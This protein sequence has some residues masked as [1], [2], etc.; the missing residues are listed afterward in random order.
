MGQA[1][2][3]VVFLFIIWKLAGF[4]INSSRHRKINCKWI[5]NK[6]NSHLNQNFEPI[7]LKVFKRVLKTHLNRLKFERL[8]ISAMDEDNILAMEFEIPD[9]GL[10]K[11]EINKLTVLTFGGNLLYDECAI[12]LNEFQAEQQL[13]Q[14]RCSHLFHM[15][16]LKPWLESNH[17]CPLCRQDLR[18]FE[19][20]R[21]KKKKNPE[22]S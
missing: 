3:I 10:N 21:K 7:F 4:Y 13:F 22:T 16:C 19:Q 1:Y 5:W 17:C 20:K 6:T 11:R 2:R 9:I 8:F 15:A 18:I 14:L 12:C